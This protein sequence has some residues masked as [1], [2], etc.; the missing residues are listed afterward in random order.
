LVKLGQPLVAEIYLKVKEFSILAIPN[1]AEYVTICTESVPSIFGHALQLGS[2]GPMFCSAL[3]KAMLAF[4]PE[5]QID[6]IL[7]GSPREKVTQYSN[8]SLTKIKASLAETRKTG[9]SVSREESIAG[10]IGFAAPV[11]SATG[12]PVAAFGVGLPASHFKPEMAKGIELAL[13]AAARQLSEQLG[14]RPSNNR[15]PG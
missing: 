1:G 15:F 4:M 13:K 10:V 12:A 8:T 3:G 11:F 2:R 6:E 5:D 14:W 9:I 7:R